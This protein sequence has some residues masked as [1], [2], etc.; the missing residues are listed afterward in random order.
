MTATTSNWF[1]SLMLLCL[2]I[3]VSP[4][5]AQQ[6]VRGVV[7]DDRNNN[8]IKDADER[9]VS[10]VIV[11]DQ[12]NVVATDDQGRYQMQPRG[13]GII[14]V[15]TPDGYA[16]KKFWQR[17]DSATEINFPLQKIAPASSFTF[18]Q[19]SDTHLNEKS[20]GRMDKLRAI[21]DSVR[22]AL[23]VITGDLVKDALRVPEKEATRLYELFST[24][25]K[26]MNAP[27]WLVPGNHEIF[28][29]ERQSSL[30]SP[31]NPLYG[32]KMYRHYFGPDYYSF[33]YG[34]VHFIGLNSVEFEDLYYY[35]RID[36]VQ[37]EWLRKDAATVPSNMPTITFQHIPFYSGGMSLDN[38]QEDGFNRSVEREHGVLQY[39]HV[40]SN[41]DE[42]M[43]I[44]GNHNYV[45]ALAGHDH[46]QQ[47]LSF[48]GVKTRFEQTAAVIGPVAGDLFTFPSGVTVYHV[49]NGKIEGQFVRLDR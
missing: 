33:N 31:Q 9:G 20:I 27:L 36:S 18:I 28:G 42:V 35:G 37:L 17:T 22:P 40:V 39:R 5:F 48:E 10:G 4:S 34:G 30:V 32:R 6:T 45:L 47:K 41:S 7:F 23:V 29:I 25:S 15:S 44:L 11:S 2:S 24:E 46:F 43:K 3:T 26:K 14:Y 1:K 38:F 12:V 13:F 19:A 21:V 49:I 8:G 16:S